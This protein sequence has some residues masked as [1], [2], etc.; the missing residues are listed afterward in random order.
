MTLV[1]AYVVLISAGIGACAFVVEL[2]LRTRVAVGRWVW[3]GALVAV[4][5]ATVFAVV[6]PLPVSEA[7]SVAR[8]ALNVDGLT[9]EPANVLAAAAPTRAQYILSLGDAVLPVAWPLGSLLLLLVIA[10]GQRRLVRERRTA[11]PLQLNGRDVLLTENLGPAVAGLA[12]PV[13]FVPRWV[14]ALDDASR[15]LLLAH[16]FEHVKQRDTR[17]LHAGAIMTAVLPWN[18]V[19]WWIARRLR[20]AV[21]SDCDARVLAAHPNVRR[22]AD[23]LLT[24]ASRHGLSTRLLAAHLGE[25]HSDLEARIHA[26]T[27]RKLRWRHALA[28]V[29]VASALVVVSCEAPRPEPLAPG[30]KSTEPPSAVSPNTILYEHQVEKPVTMAPGSE[31][32]RYPAILREAGVEGEVLVSFVVDQTGQAD[33]ATFKVIRSTHELFAT[34]VKSAL[35]AMRFVPAEVGGKKVKQRVEQPFSFAIA[36]STSKGGTTARPEGALSEIAVTG[37]EGGKALAYTVNRKDGVPSQE[38]NVVVLSFDGIVLARSQRDRNVLEKIAP[39][40]IHRIEVF[41][42]SECP[43]TMTCPLIKITLAKGQTLGPPPLI[44]PE[45]EETAA[46]SPKPQTETRTANRFNLSEFL[47][48]PMTVELLNSSGE[49]VAR[50]GNRGEARGINSEDISASEAY[51]GKHCRAGSACP[52]TRIWLKPGR[53]EAYRKR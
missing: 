35:P 9:L 43:A 40:S 2:A 8:E 34:A 48:A 13:V 50:Y 11:S 37:V 36:G 39:Q 15:E 51:S 18:P 20:L 21:E 12:D 6:A 31:T 23:L 27:D 30:D 17:M 5:G 42:P 14:L 24:A 49:V 45:R 33:V 1:M 3:V 41:K 52:L 53:E 22:Y 28:A 32:P 19:V 7:T 46:G 26:M 44:R 29:L 47:S 25:H 16:E 4:V 10:Y 38:P